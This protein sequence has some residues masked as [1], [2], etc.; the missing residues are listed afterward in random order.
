MTST[1]IEKVI[2]DRS[3]KPILVVQINRPKVKN[4]VDDETARLLHDAFLSFAEDDH[5]KLPLR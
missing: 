3:Y 5:H 1:R 2:V 4:A